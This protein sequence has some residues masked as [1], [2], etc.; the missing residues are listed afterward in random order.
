MKLGVYRCIVQR[1]PPG[2]NF[3]ATGPISGIPTPKCDTI[4]VNEARL[5]V[6]LM[7]IAVGN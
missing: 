2:S 1:S 3:R 7:G 4:N 6:T 5:D